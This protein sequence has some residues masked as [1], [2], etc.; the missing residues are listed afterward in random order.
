MPLDQQIAYVRSRIPVSSIV[1]SGGS[2][3][4]FI[5]SLETPLETYEEYM[6]VAKRL[7]LLVPEADPMCKNPSRLSRLPGRLRPDTEKTQ[8]LI[9]MNGRIPNELL[10]ARLPD[11]PEYTKR[12]YTKDEKKQFVTVNVLTAIHDPQEVMN[13][14][15]MGRNAFFFWL[16]NRFEEVELP[17]EKRAKF[18]S[19]AYDN[20]TSNN[21]FTFEE[22]CAAARLEF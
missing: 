22:A 11:L 10:M 19:I 16:F 7:L 5:I 6:N 2:S 18:V 4:H 14:T 9:Y 3:Y 15:G 13:R 21:D 1:Y 12:E 8:D 20:L 17:E